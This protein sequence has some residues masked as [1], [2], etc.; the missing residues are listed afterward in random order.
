MNPL[1]LSPSNMY[2]SGNDGGVLLGEYTNV[3][4][5]TDLYIQDT[6]AVDMGAIKVAYKGTL[7]IAR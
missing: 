5:G 7:T 3:T 1:S 4:I 6:T 2:G